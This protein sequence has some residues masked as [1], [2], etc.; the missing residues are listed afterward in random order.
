MRVLLAQSAA[1][2]SAYYRIDEPAAAVRAAGLDVEVTVRRGLATTT[3]RGGD[4]VL[5]VDSEGAD[6]VVLQLPKTEAMLQCIRVL[7][8][9]GVAVVVEMDDLLTGV[10]YGHTAHK[11]LVRQG[12]GKFALQCG[13]EADLVTASTPAL[14]QEY[15]SHGRGV[16]VPNAIPRR[17]AELP[18]AYERTPQTVTVGWSGNVLGH[19]YDL[20]EM[21]SGLQQ[22]LDRTQPLSRLVVLGQ[23]WDLRN[24]LR[25]SQEPEEV[26]WVF[27]VDGYT[28]R[29]GE[30]FDVGLAP[31]R[32]DRF[33]E[34]KSWLKPLEYSARGV[35]CVRARTSEYERLGLGLPARAPK[36]WA[37]WISLGVQDGDRRRE[38]AA[39]AHE[40]VL[41]H[42]LTEHTAERWVQAWRAALDNRARAAV[43][44][45]H[46]RTA[47]S[48]VPVPSA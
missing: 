39:A 5:D 36:D 12:R 26:P 8:E 21:G 44:S 37:K 16:V 29:M 34:C 19:P 25:L 23:K 24:R 1:A 33:N 28:T 17:I 46:A 9:R 11:T 47:S 31:L 38:V 20:Q 15:A 2:A 43:P 30:L 18:P 42:H 32:Q 7:Q 41:A 13:R 10:P 45:G 3:S 27:D 40:Q 22:A 14:L 4:E 6:V 48:A 35:F